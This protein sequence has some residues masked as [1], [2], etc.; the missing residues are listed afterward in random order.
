MYIIYIIYINIYIYIY[1]ESIIKVKL[2][3]CKV[4]IKCNS[5][6]ELLIHQKESIEKNFP[7]NAADF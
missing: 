3:I 1:K 4:K 5:K 7:V 2:N 6:I